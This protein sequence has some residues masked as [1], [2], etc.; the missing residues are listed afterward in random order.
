MIAQSFNQIM[1]P[2]SQQP[3]LSQTLSQDA[4]LILSEGI[5]IHL[6]QI[7][8]AAIIHSRKR[9]NRTATEHFVKSQLLIEKDLPGSGPGEVVSVNRGNLG[10]LWGPP[11]LEELEEHILSSNDQYTQRRILLVESIKQ[12]LTADEEK[13][14][15]KK[16]GQNTLPTA[17][18]MQDPWWIRDEKMR[19][20]GTASLEEIAMMRLR[21]EVAKKHEL[22]P[23]NTSRNKKARKEEDMEQGTLS[24]P[25]PPFLT[26]LCLHPS[27]LSLAF[28]LLS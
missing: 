11:R 12:D 26:L 13:R 28:D 22:G 3:H 9:T 23:H 1:K 7:I 19:D 10:M 21:Q 18:T 25:P 27:P 17:G 24:P 8:D 14:L 6:T 15:Q 4:A 2:Y 16:K 5:Q 20:G